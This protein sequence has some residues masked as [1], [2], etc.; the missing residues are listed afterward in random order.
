VPQGGRRRERS[1]KKRSRA[2]QLRREKKAIPVVIWR[3]E[4]RKKWSGLWGV[5][6]SWFRW[7]TKRTETGGH[8]PLR[9]TRESGTRRRIQANEGF[10][11]RWPGHEAGKSNAKFPPD[12]STIWS[13]LKK[14]V[15]RGR[16]TPSTTPD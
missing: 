16:V 9:G 4:E 15:I 11:V 2:L 7:D 1:L 3:R 5:Y 12:A 6:E 8:V 10:H 13:P 14:R